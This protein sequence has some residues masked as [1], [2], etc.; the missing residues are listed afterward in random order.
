MSRFETR[1]RGHG[2]RE[3]RRCVVCDN[4]FWLDGRKDWEG[5]RTFAR[6]ESTRT[7]PGV[8]GPVKSVE[9]RYYIS[10]LGLDAERMSSVIRSHWSI[11]NNLHWQ[12]DVT[13]NEDDD[14]K[15]N[16]AAQ[17]FSVI[18]KVALAMLK[19]DKTKKNSIKTKRKGAGWDN[20]YLHL[21][22]SQDVF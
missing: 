1:E 21:L 20:E 22:L 5:L 7:V 13:F 18:S 9:T 11:E 16:N 14:R 3:E 10:S 15:R 8:N 6:V 2:R 19:N 17:N 12:L 4:L